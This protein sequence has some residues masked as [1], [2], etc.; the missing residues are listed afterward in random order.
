MGIASDFLPPLPD[1]LTGT[2]VTLKPFTEGDITPDYVAWLN[3]PEIMRFSNQRFRRHTAETCRDYLASFVDSPNL[4]LKIVRVSDGRTI[5]TMTA[6]AAVPH[7]TVDLGI[8]VGCRSAWG[9]GLGRDAWQTLLSW[10]LGE[11]G[12]RK[13]TGGTMRCNLGMVRIMER[14]GMTL[15]AVRPQQELLDGLPQDLVYYGKFPTI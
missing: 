7:R 3:D 15:E 14:C 12:V 11:P 10:L 6:Y 2:S 4:F 1:S 13:V 8:L 9:Q 5:G